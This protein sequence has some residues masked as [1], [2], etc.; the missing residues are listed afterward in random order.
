MPN[1]RLLGSIINKKYLKVADPLNDI[2]LQKFIACF[3][4]GRRKRE[5]RDRGRETGKTAPGGK[6]G[7]PIKQKSYV[8]N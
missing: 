4:H 3:K 6:K 8:R 2:P 7:N 1:F 5:K